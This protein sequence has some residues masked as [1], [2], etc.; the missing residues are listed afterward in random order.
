MNLL[1]YGKLQVDPAKLSETVNVRIQQGQRATILSES[2]ETHEFLMPRIEAIHA[3]RT[4]NYNHY[5]ADKL[6]GDASIQSAFI[7]GFSLTPNR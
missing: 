2:S 7:P 4:R 1:K 5:P 3:G 6:R